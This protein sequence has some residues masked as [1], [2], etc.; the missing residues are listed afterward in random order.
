MESQITR[1][2]Q[3][4]ID[5]AQAKLEKIEAAK[6]DVTRCQSGGV[7]RLQALKSQLPG[8]LAAKALGQA[9]D[10]E[11]MALKRDIADLESVIND[12]GLTLTGLE[13]IEKP[14]QASLREPRRLLS[15]VHKYKQLR[16]EIGGGGIGGVSTIRTLSKVLGFESDCETFLS[17]QAH[18]RT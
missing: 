16:E 10:G 18:L 5:K 4:Q 17:G 6:I 3:S 2:A 8:L 15:K 13:A 11:V 9:T 12:A 7:D 1:E 14:L